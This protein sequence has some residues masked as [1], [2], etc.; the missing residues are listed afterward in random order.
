MEN[1]KAVGKSIMMVDFS[2][3][4]LNKVKDKDLGDI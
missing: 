2:K 3:V 1:L 4:L